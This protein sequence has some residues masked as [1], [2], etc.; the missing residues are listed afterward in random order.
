MNKGKMRTKTK[1]LQY[2]L[3]LLIVGAALFGAFASAQAADKKPNIVIIWGDDI[4]A[5]F[6]KK[7]N[8]LGGS[9]AE[10]CEDCF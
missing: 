3:S 4:G 5:G 8:Y 9:I 2:G 1:L 7:I 6:A 10:H